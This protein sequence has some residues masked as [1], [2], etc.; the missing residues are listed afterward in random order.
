MAIPMLL[1]G[2]RNQMVTF[3]KLLG[4]PELPDTGWAAAKITIIT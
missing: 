2:T 3:R 1:G 4:L